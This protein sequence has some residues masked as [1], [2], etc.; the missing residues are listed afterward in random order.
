MNRCKCVNILHTMPREPICNLKTTHA[1]SPYTDIAVTFPLFTSQIRTSAVGTQYVFKQPSHSSREDIAPPKPR[2]YLLTSSV[3]AYTVLPGVILASQ[4]RFL[5]RV[6]RR[7]RH[8]RCFLSKYCSNLTPTPYN[9]CTIIFAASS[10]SHCGF[11]LSQLP[12]SFLVF[13]FSHD[14]GVTLPAPIL[15]IR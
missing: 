12:V 15:A 13:S 14:R 7:P 2:L 9:C 5:R 3:C 8:L 1:H 6:L 4:V 11:H 10:P